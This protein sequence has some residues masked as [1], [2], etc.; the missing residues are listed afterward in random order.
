MRQRLEYTKLWVMWAILKNKK[1]VRETSVTVWPMPS[2]LP[3]PPQILTESLQPQVSEHSLTAAW[4]VSTNLS[5]LYVS[6]Y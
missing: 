4:L 3:P 5:N 1:I 6:A 2:A